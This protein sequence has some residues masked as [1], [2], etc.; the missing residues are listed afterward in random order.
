MSTSNTTATVQHRTT[1]VYKLLR[2]H[3]LLTTLFY[4]WAMADYLTHPFDPGWSP[5]SFMGSVLGRALFALVL[6]PMFLIIGVLIM[7]RARGNL[8]G[9]LVTYIGLF[10][11]WGSLR[12]DALPTLGLAVALFNTIFYMWTLLM[13]VY[14]PDGRA[15]PRWTEPLYA[16]VVICTYVISIVI[17]L[18]SPDLS[19]TWGSP[20]ANA[21]YIPAL[22]EL[23]Q[24]I[25]PISNLLFLPVIIGV[26]FS[27]ILRYRAS[28]VGS[29]ER[30]Q[31]K[32]LILCAAC[33][34]A[35]QV[36]YTIWALTTPPDH[37]TFTPLIEI[38]YLTFFTIMPPLALGLAI[39]RH[40]LYDIDIIIRRTL[41]YSI[42]TSILALVFFGGVTLAQ[43]LFRAATGQSSDLAIVASTLM[44]AA[45]FTPLRRRI[46]S[47]IDH[48]F[49]RRKYDAEKTL[50]RFSQTLREE[51][52]LEALKDSM[53]SVVRETM[54]PTH[55]ALWIQKSE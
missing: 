39:L 52:N 28:A 50:A 45:L 36:W 2:L 21:L 20:I 6:S 17:T 15:F 22:H 26:I 44:I 33:L 49:Y 42:L 10:N 19:A 41:I 4:M 25:A 54:Q 46:Q 31:I 9:P 32:W 3:L 1:F 37:L 11:I 55:V 34:G 5:S 53:I 51:T 16:V 12:Y 24:A 35:Y 43:S 13:F 40:R 14:F 23:A 27:P 38:V 48:R 47:A 18:G 30:Q 29:R 8:M 7:R